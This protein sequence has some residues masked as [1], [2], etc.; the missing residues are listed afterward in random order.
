MSLPVICI[1][2]IHEFTA[3]RRWQSSVWLDHNIRGGRSASNYRQCGREWSNSK[4]WRQSCIPSQNKLWV[5]LLQFVKMKI[6]LRKMSITQIL[7]KFFVLVFGN[8]NLVHS[9]TPEEL[10]VF[11]GYDQ[12][13]LPFSYCFSSLHTLITTFQ[14]IHCLVCPKAYKGRGWFHYPIPVTSL[15]WWMHRL[16]YPYQLPNNGPHLSPHTK[17]DVLRHT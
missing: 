4:T 10:S 6:H 7:T 1:N 15:A 3:V 2:L 13:N 16:L 11:L 9:N 5:T 17:T 8:D 14:S 12:G